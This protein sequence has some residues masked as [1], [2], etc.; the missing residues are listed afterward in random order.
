MLRLLSDENFSGPIVRGMLRREPGL[1][2]IRV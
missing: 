1:D 2:L